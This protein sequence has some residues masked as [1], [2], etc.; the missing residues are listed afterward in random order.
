MNLY[1]YVG[2][3]PANNTDPSGE[4]TVVALKANPLGAYPTGGNYGHAFVEYR[5]TETG[6]TRISRAGPTARVSTIAV[7]LG[8][9]SGG[10]VLATDT[11]ASE[12]IDYGAEGQIL[13]SETTVPETIGEVRGTLEAFNR[14]VNAAESPY[15]ARRNNSNTYAGDAFELVTGEIPENTSELDLPAL[16]SEL[17]RVE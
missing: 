10:Q 4:D 15:N 8:V 9:N 17:E 13:I 6:E 12:S 1:A 5:D 7:L 11:P 16:D 14:K 3:D 2:N